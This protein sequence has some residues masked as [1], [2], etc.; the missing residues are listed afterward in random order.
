M[1]GLQYVGNG[2]GTPAFLLP[3]QAVLAI[4]VMTMVMFEEDLP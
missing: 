2:N 3:P 1:C 4:V